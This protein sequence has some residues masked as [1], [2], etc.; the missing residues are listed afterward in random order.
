MST[1]ANF[2]ATAAPTRPRIG[3]GM[4]VYNGE[5]H[6]GQSIES[7]L[8]QTFSNLE[9]VISDNQSTDGTETI[10]RQYAKLDKRIRYVRNDRNCGGPG[11]FT[12]VFGLCRGEYHKWATADDWCEHTMLDKAIRQLDHH[13]DLVLVYPKTCLV[14]SSGTITDYFEDHLDLHEDTPSDRFIRV[15]ETITLCHAHLGV[16]RRAAMASTG[17]IGGEIGSDSRFVAEISLYG[18]LMVLPEHLFFRRFH[19]SSSSWDRSDEERQRRYYAPDKSSSLG[20]DLW[21]RLHGL[22]AAVWRAPIDPRQ[23]WIIVRYLGRVARHRR[24]ELGRE[25]ARLLSR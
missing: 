18:K 11:N 4:P 8:G 25:L 7:I 19:E 17:L 14:N 23:K 6:I 3:I 9:L 20:M 24:D 21:R 15:L 2:G 10:C 16:I 12:R 1:A 13:P 22:L 5:A